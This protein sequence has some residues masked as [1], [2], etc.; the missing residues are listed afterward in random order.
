MLLTEENIESVIPQ[1][2]PFVMVSDLIEA[3]PL[4]F[5]SEFFVRAENIFVK[6]G[7]LQEAAL[8]E[9]IAQTCAAGFGFLNK[10][11]GIKPSVGFIGAITKLKVHHLPPVNS[12]IKTTAIVA[13]QLE[14][15]YLIKGQNF[16]DGKILL[17]CELKIV[18]T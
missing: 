18:V 17:E 1:R 8:I 10:Q 14:N 5:E 16:L 15:V 6:N 7:I 11:A 3:T 2:N 4:K 13:H 9:N 12:Q